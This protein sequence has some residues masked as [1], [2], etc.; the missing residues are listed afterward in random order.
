MPSPSPFFLEGLPP[1]G[2]W[3]SST[4]VHL[5]VEADLTCAFLVFHGASGGC[6]M[7]LAE[8]LSL[9]LLHLWGPALPFGDKKWGEHCWVL[10][11]HK[12]YRRHSSWRWA[13]GHHG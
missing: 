8:P 1:L 11:P 6:M 10:L 3:S 7:G 5:P 13:E 4:A 2:F 12:P 9:T